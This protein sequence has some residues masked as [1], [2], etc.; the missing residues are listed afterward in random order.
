MSDVPTNPG[1]NSGVTINGQSITLPMGT[2][3]L[4]VS[5]L[6]G[7]GGSAGIQSIFSV[8]QEVLDRIETLEDRQKE[9]AGEVAETKRVVDNT[10]DIV[11]AAHPPRGRVG[12]PD[13]Q[14]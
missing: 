11:N 7:A 8:D 3:L 13:D 14:E 9:I 4:L 10:F 1:T 12:V 2:V 6:L 5:A